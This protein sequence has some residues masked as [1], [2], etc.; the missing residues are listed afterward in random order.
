MAHC[1]VQMLICMIMHLLLL[2]I[3]WEPVSKALYTRNTTT[4]QVEIEDHIEHGNQPRM[5]S[6]R[7][8]V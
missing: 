3:I 1:V 8:H 2:F 4:G 7:F 6:T 5:N